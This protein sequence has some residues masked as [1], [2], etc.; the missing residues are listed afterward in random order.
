MINFDTK[1]NATRADIPVCVNHSSIDSNTNSGFVDT[2]INSSF[3]DSI[4]DA[5]DV[6]S[7]AFSSFVYKK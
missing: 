5:I 6:D 7:N 2:N 3:T 1:F 4:T